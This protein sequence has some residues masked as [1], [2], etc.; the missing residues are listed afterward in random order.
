MRGFVS[1]VGAG[2]WDPERLTLAGRDRLARADFVL[3]DYL[4][5]PALF[6]HCPPHCEV[7]QRSAGPRGGTDI[8]QDATTA[9]LIE[10]ARAG[11]RVVRLKGG[12]PCMFGRGG[13][14]AQ[15]LVAA[16]IP[17]EL[18]PGVSS[19]I[20]APE[21]AGIPVTHRD[22]T[23]AV[24]FVSGWEAYEK[25][26]LAVQWEHL[27][28]SAG[29]IVLLMGVR[30][31]ELNA[32]K[33]VEAGRDASTPAAAIRWGT[34]GIQRTVVATLGTI[35]QRIADEGLRAPA[36]LVVGEVVALREELAWLESRPLFGKRVV[37]TR[38]LDQGVSLAS[39]LA[40]AGADVAALPCLAIAPPED[41][42]AFAAAIAAIDA[43]DGVIVSSKNGVVE[44]GR[45]LR[46]AGLDARVLAGRRVVAIGPATAAA[47]HEIGL[48]ADLVPARANAEGLMAAL[49]EH[50][51]TNA[52]WLHVRAADG[53][54]ILGDAIAAAG[55]RYT[56][57]IA[58]RSIRPSVPPLL[59]RSLLAADA[60]G[61]GM[62]AI[63]CASGQTAA[64]MLAT[65]GEAWGDP[66]TRERI[67]ATRMIAI[68]PVTADA[69]RALGLP[70]HAV[71]QS[72]DDDAVVR[73]VIAALA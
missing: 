56:L 59:L 37:V 21:S 22:F 33:L 38:A 31:A 49:R 8:D 15:A 28:R 66:L 12:D 57:A 39:A 24:T 34:R 62:D 10:R 43:H 7:H 20:A 11:L 27:A 13:E 63:C 6:V 9:L 69:I 29:T 42:A 67:S 51:W 1:L 61:E 48:R 55:G 17:F 35:A 60:G 44:L 25:S 73:A 30:N 40:T 52:S 14:E 46:A 26:G 58:Y 65:M 54:R 18:V 32:R 5:N 23:P 72:T 68:G 36:V 2:P 64:N 70:V 45:A 4:V 16:G 47:L 53:R 41:P 71:A 19:P 3:A 50:G